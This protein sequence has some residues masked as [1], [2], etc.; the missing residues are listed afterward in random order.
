MEDEIILFE[1]GK[2]IEQKKE[3][4]QNE[5]DKENQKDQNSSQE[6][7][8]YEKNSENDIKFEPQSKKEEEN[9]IL[10]PE[11]KSTYILKYS[12]NKEELR[13]VSKDTGLKKAENCSFMLNIKLV[14]KNSSSNCPQNLNNGESDTPTGEEKLLVI[15]CHEIAAFSFDEIYERKYELEDLFKESRYFRIF[16][17]LDEVKII[18]DELI[19]INQNNPHK[20]FIEFKDNTL[21]IHMKLSFFDKEKE[22]ILN[23]PKKQLSDE[24]KNNLL[25]GFL[26][27]IQEKMNRLDK[28]YKILKFNNLAHSD[29][30]KE[31]KYDNIDKKKNKL[32]KTEIKDDESIDESVNTNK[33]NI[34]KR[35]ISKSKRKK[36]N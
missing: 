6:T 5:E 7:S 36:I 19:Q 26:K 10:D 13:E 34:L 33:S 8:Q 1:E 32:N 23:I 16:E 25:P 31:F 2:N 11:F 27:E 4:L 28:E 35:I 29:K 18:I 21:K 20:F 3:N 30:I 17:S 9:K 14:S 15:Y 12:R 22:M 24:E